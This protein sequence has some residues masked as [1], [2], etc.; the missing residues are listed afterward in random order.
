MPDQKRYRTEYFPF[1]TP[2]GIQKK[3][4]CIL[5]G[6]NERERLL[7][8]AKEIARNNKWKLR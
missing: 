2:K 1:L 4:V 7:K 8:K 5:A 3:M 6:E